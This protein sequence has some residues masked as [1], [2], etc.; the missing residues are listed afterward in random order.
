MRTPRT[1]ITCLAAVLI[2]LPL[3]SVALAGDDANTY[4]AALEETAEKTVIAEDAPEPPEWEKPVPIS[5][6][7]DY[8]VV[9]DYIFRGV[10]FSEYSGEGREKLNHMLTAG[11][12]YD[13]GDFGAI[14]F[15]SWFE[16]YA[17]QESLDP[18]SDGNLQEVDYVVY[19]SYDMSA[20]SESLPVSVEIGWIAYTF[21]QAAG[22]AYYTNE[23]YVSLGLDDSSLFGTENPVLSP[24][25]AYYIDVDDIK[26][27]WMEFGVS[28][29]FAL[30]GMGMDATPVLKD[31]TV[32]PSL[33]LGVDHRYVDNA[34]RLA[35]LLYGLAVSY[36]LSGALSIP[37]EY[38]SM[39]ITGFLNYSQPLS[40]KLREIALD[41]EFYG[42]VSFTYEW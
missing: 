10:N 42:G 18:A 31:M 40:D 11:V 32:T 20:L 35:N 28:H 26:G 22:D 19:W 15:S 8:T 7:V 34:T 13:T 17:G 33:V 21:P 16:W 23:W 3:A 6:L 12:E 38:G 37:E 39:S 29:D 30:A 14:G 41:D 2:G 27:S 9:T 25:L 24:S 4:L 5:F 36:D 1:W